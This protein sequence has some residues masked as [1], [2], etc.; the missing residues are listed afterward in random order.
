M[1][2]IGKADLRAS[3]RDVIK[4]EMDKQQEADI[5]KTLEKNLE[6]NNGKRPM[7]IEELRQINLEDSYA[8][9]WRNKGTEQTGCV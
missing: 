8:D 9:M 4:S 7:S 2:K 6:G 1:V 5:K 3:L